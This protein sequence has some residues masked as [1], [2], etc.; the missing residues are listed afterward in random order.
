MSGDVLA[1]Q[2][3][4]KD[5]YKD[6][7]VL[8]KVKAV[9]MARMIEAIEEYLRSYYG[10]IRV[11]LACIIRKIIIG[12]TYDDFP[13]DAII[14]MMLHLPIDRTYCTMNRMLSQSLSIFH[15]MKYTTGVSMTSSV[16]IC[17]TA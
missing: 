13:K 4:L 6:P 9:D 17:Q 15:S 7:N 12:Q 2:K 10:V 1:G 3:R 14:T 5:E 16:P 8:P 11:P